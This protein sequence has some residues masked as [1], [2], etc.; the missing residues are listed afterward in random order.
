MWEIL[1]SPNTPINH[2]WQKISA[3]GPRIRGIHIKTH[4]ISQPGQNECITRSWFESVLI[5]FFIYLF[6]CNHCKICEQNKANCNPPKLMDPKFSASENLVIMPKLWLRP[7]TSTRNFYYTRPQH[8]GGESKSTFLVEAHLR[9]CNT[10][11]PSQQHVNERL[12]GLTDHGKVSP[13][14]PCPEDPHRWAGE[15][16]LLG[17]FWTP[18]LCCPA[19]D[20]TLG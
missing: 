10:P 17:N 6:M 14:L 9:L 5:C 11:P 2:V 12:W 18:V 16:A 20:A 19:S 15:Q 13:Q 8:R 3:L 7:W 4:T 1:R